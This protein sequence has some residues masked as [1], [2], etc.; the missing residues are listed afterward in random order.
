M[1]RNKQNQRKGT[2]MSRK[3]PDRNPAPLPSREEVAQER[4][5]LKRREYF[6]RSLLSTLGFLTVVAAVSVLV[7]TQLLPV[8]QISGGSREPALADGEIVILQKTE[9]LETGDIIAFYYQSRIL[10]KRVIGKAGDYIDID[11]N[12]TV[13]VNGEQLEEP[14]VT[15]P[16][17]GDCDLT[18]PYQVPE[19]RLFVL[20]D[21]RSVSMDSRSRAI[22]CV[23]QEQIV[24]KIIFRV[25]PLG[26]LGFLE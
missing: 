15:E 7:A 5:R 12:G 3:R 19:G 24:G 6:R 23:A 9:D 4:Q 22:G 16:S 8:V 2:A 11:E 14:Y 10:I 17:L 13:T 1:R 20:G 26:R 21:H 18:F 25:W